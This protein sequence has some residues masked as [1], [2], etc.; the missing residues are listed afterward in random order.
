MLK[1]FT[2]KNIGQVASLKNELRNTKMT[3]ED[4]VATFFV[5]IARLKD[6]ILAIDEIVLDKELVIPAILG[7]PPYWG[8]FV[9]VSTVGR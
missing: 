1:L 7:L 3:K 5:R 6:D 9:Q 2:I 8:A 4:T